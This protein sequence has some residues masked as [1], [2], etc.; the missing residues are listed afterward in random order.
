MDL[1][2]DGVWYL[3]MVGPPPVAINTAR[4]RT[5]R[6]MP[7]A[8]IH[9]Q[10]AAQ[11]FSVA[12]RYQSQRT[13]FF[14][15]FHRQGADLLHQAA[16]DFDA[17]EIAFV[18]GTIIGLAGERL[19][20]QRTVRVSIEKAAHLVFQFTHPRD[21]GFTQFPG[22]ILIRQPLAAVYGIHEVALH[23]V[24]G[25][26]CNVITALHHTGASG[27]PHQSLDGYGHGESRGGFFCVQR[28]EQAGAA[29]AQDQ[30]VCIVLLEHG[31]VRRI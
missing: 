2:P 14:H 28:G 7:L 16:D 8:H 1:S 21:C 13:M 20:V 30:D 4:A 3:Y 11:L 26:Q 23:R 6:N 15:Q 19:V 24:A 27:F 17:G 31:W 18:Y 10:H 9:Q 29:A 22:H 25:P 12:V 5:N